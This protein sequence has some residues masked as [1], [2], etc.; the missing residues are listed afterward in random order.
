MPARGVHRAST[1]ELD[2]IF[3]L[4]QRRGHNFHLRRMRGFHLYLVDDMK[5]EASTVAQCS[6][7]DEFIDNLD[8]MLLPD[9]AREIEEESAVNA[10]LT[11]ASPGLIRSDS[12]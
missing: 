4:H 2:G 8:E 9:L 3:Q 7:L 12:I 5:L 1:G 10:T 6:D 11:R